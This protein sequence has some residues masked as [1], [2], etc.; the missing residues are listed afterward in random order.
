MKKKIG[1][2][3][4]DLN[5]HEIYAEP[6]LS[7]DFEEQ[8]GK[9][10][11]WPTHSIGKTSSTKGEFKGVVG[12]LSGK[13]HECCSYGYQIARSI[14]YALLGTD[15]GAKYNGRGF[16]FRASLEAIEKASI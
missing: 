4:K 5:S 15:S 2:W 13:D 16:S 6:E 1:E 10:A 8:T 11:C 14:E 9:V 3:L 12:E 7:K